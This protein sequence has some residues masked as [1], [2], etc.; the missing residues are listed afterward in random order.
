[1]AREVDIGKPRVTSVF[2]HTTA[3]GERCVGPF[4]FAG[5]SY[6]IW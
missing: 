4:Y 6:L 1:V 5:G 2:T 3:F